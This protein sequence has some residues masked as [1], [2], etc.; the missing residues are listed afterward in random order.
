VAVKAKEDDNDDIEEDGKK[1]NIAS[2]SKNAESNNT[3][4]RSRRK[5]KESGV[6]RGIDFQHLSNVINFDFPLDSASYLHRVG[7]TAR[8]N[9]QGAAL[10]FVN[11]KEENLL[12][13][14]ESMLQELSCDSE[15]RMKP[16]NFKMNEVEGFRYRAKDAW[17]AVTR[18]AIRE[19]RIKEIRLE[20]MNSDKLKAY[21]K[22]NPHELKA[23]RHDKAMK[24]IKQ[25]P[26]LKN[27]PDYIVPK[28]LKHLPISRSSGE[29][30]H[31][32][33]STKSRNKRKQQGKKKGFLK[34]RKADPLQSMEF[35]GINKKKRKKSS[36]LE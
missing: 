32:V 24:T 4:G 34:A 1:G 7:R 33:F 30:S 11:V 5:D 23:L 27:V 36:V 22:T 28:T 6:S 21:F 16:F 19:A 13:E 25:Q 10:S 9:N 17:K 31:F 20:M 14:V 15:L 18:I 2:S 8:G 35:S 29:G 3:E 12:A 26:H